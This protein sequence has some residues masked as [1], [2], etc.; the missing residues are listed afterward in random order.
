MKKKIWTKYGSIEKIFPKC[1]KHCGIRVFFQFSFFIR[2]LL[3]NLYFWLYYS[4]IGLWLAFVFCFPIGFS[5]PFSYWLCLQLVSFSLI[6]IFNL[7]T[8]FIVEVVFFAPR[9]E[10]RKFFDGPSSLKKILWL[11]LERSFNS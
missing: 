9:E 4:M 1:K 6:F 7:A 5:I 3:C 11:F 2:L 8:T 10:R